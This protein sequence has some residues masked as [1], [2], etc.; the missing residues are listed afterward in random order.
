HSIYQP[1]TFYRRSAYQAVG[2]VDVGLRFTMDRDLVTKLARRRRL[3]RL[4]AMLSGSRVHPATKSETLQDVCA[5]ETEGLM[6][7]YGARSAPRWQQRLM[8]WRYRI[9]GQL[10]KAGWALRRGLGLQP[11]PPIVYGRGDGEAAVAGAQDLGAP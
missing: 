3:H 4:G 1:S 2:G 9:P 11:L 8:Y 5:Q 6:V 7:R 10:A